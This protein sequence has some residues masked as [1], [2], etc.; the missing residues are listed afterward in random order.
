MVYFKYYFFLCYFLNF[1]HSNQLSL[2][3]FIF[4]FLLFYIF[5]F[6]ISN[7]NFNLQFNFSY[8]M[9]YL[10][11]LIL[12]FKFINY[13]ISYYFFLNF[14][15]DPSFFT[16]FQESE[17]GLIDF[18]FQFMKFLIYQ[19]INFKLIFF[20]SIFNYLFRHHYQVLLI[21]SF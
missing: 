1:D 4:D 12:N 9:F 20:I 10:F 11:I 21:F 18:Y 14:I 17:N 16:N 5:I 13:Q 19:I 3:Y 8:F 7:L 2:Y 6:F 15:V